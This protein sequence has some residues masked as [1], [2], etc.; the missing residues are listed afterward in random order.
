MKYLIGVLVAK[1]NIDKISTDK[2]YTVKLRIQAQGLH[3][4]TNIFWWAYTR[5]WLIHGTTFVSGVFHTSLICISRKRNKAKKQCSCSKMPF[6]YLTVNKTRDVFHKLGPLAS[7][8]LKNTFGGAL[9]SVDVLKTELLHKFL[10]YFY[11]GLVFGEANIF[12]VS[13]LMGLYPRR[14]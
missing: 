8:G 3:R 2:V 9:I 13:I 11:N 4:V 6:Y 7:L 14:L 12:C 10:S 1:T 5:G